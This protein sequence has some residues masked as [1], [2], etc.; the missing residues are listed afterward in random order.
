MK[1]PSIANEYKIG[2]RKNEQTLKVFFFS[3]VFTPETRNQTFRAGILNNLDAFK[4]VRILEGSMAYF[5]AKKLATFFTWTAIFVWKPLTES[6]ATRDQKM[7]LLR[8]E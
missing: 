3:P 6:N 5:S 7:R 8:M 2:T 1:K 4:Q